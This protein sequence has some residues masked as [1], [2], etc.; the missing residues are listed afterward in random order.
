MAKNLIAPCKE[1]AF[2]RTIK[3]GELGGS[4][5]QVYIGQ[6]QGPFLV[7]CHKACDFDDPEWREKSFDTPQCAGMA[8]FRAN[9]GVADQMPDMLSKLPAD[10]VNVFADEAEFLAHHAEVPLWCAKIW[11]HQFPPKTLLRQE[12]CK[13]EIIIRSVKGDPP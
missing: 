6:A 4:A 5:P 10:K 9:I 7:P 3:P 8:V 13:K 2:L 1:C 11:L 12:F